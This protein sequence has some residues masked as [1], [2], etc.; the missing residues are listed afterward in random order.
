MANTESGYK[1]RL[2]LVDDEQDLSR[3][4]ARFF[5]RQGYEVHVASGVGDDL[6]C[7]ALTKARRERCH[8]ALVDLRLYGKDSADTAGLELVEKLKPLKSIILTGTPGTEPPVLRRL[9]REKGPEPVLWKADGPKPIL[10]EI[11]KIEQTFG[12]RDLRVHWPDGWSSEQ[13]AKVL[14]DETFIPGAREPFEVIA[15]LFPEQ[16]EVTLERLDGAVASGGP[17]TSKRRS[18]VLLAYADDYQ[19]VVV[20]LMRVRRSMAEQRGFELVNGRL[21]GNF[22]S[23]LIKQVEWWGMSAVVYSLIGDSLGASGSPSKTLSLVYG[24]EQDGKVVCKAL[25][26]FFSTVWKPLYDKPTPLKASLVRLYLE[27]WREDIGPIDKALARWQAQPSTQTFRIRQNGTEQLLSTPNPLHWL[28]NHRNPVLPKA[29]QSIIHGDLHGEN[30]LIDDREIAWSIDFGRTREGH[31]LA[32]FSQLTQYIYTRLAKLP[33]GD[34][35]LLYHLIISLTRPLRP[36]QNLTHSPLIKG[37]NEAY[38]ALTVAQTLRKIAFEVTHYVDAR[39]YLWGILLD[40]VAIWHV[41]SPTDQR[42]EKL[43]LLGGII[44]KRLDDWGHP[45]WPPSDWPQVA[46]EPTWPAVRATSDPAGHEKSLQPLKILFLAANP[47]DTVYLNLGREYQ[48]I[49]DALQLVQAR[50]YFTLMTEWAVRD[51]E[52]IRLLM[53]HQ[54]TI[55]HFSGHGSEAGEIILEDQNGKSSA[56]PQEVVGA[57]FGILNRQ[58]NRIRCVILNACFSQ[59]QAE[60]IAEHVDIVIGISAMIGDLAATQFA[61]VF[62]SVVGDGKDVQTAFDLAQAN[63]GLQRLHV[64]DILWLIPKPG[65]DPHR[66]TLV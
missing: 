22:A 61:S 64:H 2:L 40:S 56:L 28:A 6:I 4:Q 36:R 27:V 15:Q 24:R 53:T 18:V 33:E 12:Q 55:I 8:I 25:R 62:Y 21:G 54:P 65:V 58:P 43:L 45:D 14:A 48:A 42:S 39:E 1:L 11:Q 30:L 50:E 3:D 52:L 57:I 49:R 16:S 41:L 31:V 5:E 44:C 17:H 51:Q 19:P 60:A 10:E 7:D 34:L 38:K 35:T 59:R 23:R 63:L 20:K 47:S 46:G 13:V 32:D 26:Q 37:D 66:Y 29:K 9:I